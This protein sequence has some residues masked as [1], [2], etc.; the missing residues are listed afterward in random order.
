MTS[1]E[2]SAALKGIFGGQLY[3]RIGSAK[4]L[5]VGAGGIGCELLKNLALSGFSDITLVDLDTIDVTNLNRQFFFQK[6]HVG[7]SKAKVSG[8]A[9]LKYNPK[10]KVSANH[11]SIMDPKYNKSF[12]KEYDIVLNALDN[13]A[14]RKHVNRLCLSSEVPL[15][16]SGT[17]GYVGQAEV[18]YKGVECYECRPKKPPKQ[19]PVCTIRNTP[20]EPIHCIVWAKFLFSQLFGVPDDENDVTPDTADKEAQTS[21]DNATKGPPGPRKTVRMWIMEHD[22]NAVKLFHRLFYEDVETLLAMDGLWKKRKKPQPLNIDDLPTENIAGNDKLLPTQ[23]LWS[24]TECKDQFVESVNALRRRMLSSENPDLVWDKD[25]D[26]AMTFV[27]AAANL[28]SQIFGI[29]RQSYFDTKSAA[30]NIIPAIATTNAV[31]AGL[32]VLEAIKVLNGKQHECKNVYLSQQPM[33]RGIILNPAS[34]QPRNQECFACKESKEAS[35]T[36]NTTNCTIGFLRDTILRKA[37]GMNSP[38][39][40]CGT[41]LIITDD[42]DDAPIYEE[43]VYPR[44]LAERNIN[45]GTVLQCMDSLQQFEFNLTIHHSDD[46]EPS[47]FTLG[48]DAGTAQPMEEKPTKSSEEDSGPILVEEEEVFVVEKPSDQQQSQKSEL[49]RDREEENSAEQRPTKKL[50]VAT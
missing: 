43:K 40:S 41:T 32:I 29:K 27:T 17:R 12:F 49:K 38:E 8:E 3:D 45:E 10:L 44:M 15:V 30:G 7:K 18:I 33:S 16:E 2:R 25:D 50:N 14:A 23:K 11:G 4:V 9:I 34:L 35:V 6:E 26:D 47:E 46:L 48:G 20:S 24:L 39:V 36:L 1:Q 37:L 13:I 31:I 22:Y 19:Y 21:N 28:R 42:E 5:V